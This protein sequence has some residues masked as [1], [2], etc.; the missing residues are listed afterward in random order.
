MSFSFYVVCFLVIVLSYLGLFCKKTP[1]EEALQIRAVLEREKRTA[2]TVALI[3]LL[4]LITF[5]PGVLSPLFHVFARSVSYQAILPLS[6]FFLQL[7][8]L[9]NP[10]VNFGRCRDMRRALRNLL[11][12]S[13]QV[14]PST[15]ASVP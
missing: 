14:Q 3:L 9:L 15:D 10:L 12:C 8:S 5:L 2:N 11:K 6:G 13:Q 1:P 7:N 4:L